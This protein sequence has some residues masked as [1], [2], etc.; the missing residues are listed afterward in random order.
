MDFVGG[1]RVYP[2]T[3]TTTE[4]TTHPPIKNP[5][6]LSTFA[7]SSLYCEN[8]WWI[9][10]L[11]IILTAILG[12]SLTIIIQKISNRL[13]GCKKKKDGLGL[14]RAVRYLRSHQGGNLEDETVITV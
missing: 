12:A 2:L 9:F 8:N 6:T 1:N 13:Y 5:T 3:F 4:F 11:K 10:F 14:S 7:T